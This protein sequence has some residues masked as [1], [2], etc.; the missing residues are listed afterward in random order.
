MAVQIGLKTNPHARACEAVR[1]LSPGFCGAS[2]FSFSLLL[3]LN[4]PGGSTS[5]Q[6]L[7]PTRGIDFLNAQFIMPVKNGKDW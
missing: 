7:L 6:A 1:G 5:A 4:L 3:G 2:L